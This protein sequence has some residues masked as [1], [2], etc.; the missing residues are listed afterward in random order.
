M[1]AGLFRRKSGLVSPEN[2]ADRLLFSAIRASENTAALKG[3]LNLMS[4]NKL[5]GLKPPEGNMDTP[6]MRL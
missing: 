4:Q 2:P 3:F 1:C 5:Y 6:Q